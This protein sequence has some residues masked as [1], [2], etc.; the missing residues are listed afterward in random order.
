MPLHAACARSHRRARS[1]A[2]RRTR[3]AGLTR[4]EPSLAVHDDGVI[5]TLEAMP[6]EGREVTVVH[7][8]ER[9]EPIVSRSE[10]AAHTSAS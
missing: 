6:V 9:N 3:Q 10:H 2:G 5:V 8:G 4:R 1:E 7:Y